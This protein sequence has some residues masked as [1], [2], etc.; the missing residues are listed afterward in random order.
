MAAAAACNLHEEPLYSLVMK[1]N[2]RSMRATLK[3]SEIVK[4]LDT[5]LLF[6][7]IPSTDHPDLISRFDENLSEFLRLRSQ[8]LNG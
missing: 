3:T 5:Y 6:R 8:S 4:T 2:E 7:T 1:V